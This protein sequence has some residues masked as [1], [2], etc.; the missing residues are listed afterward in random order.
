M[1]PEIGRAT[2]GQKSGAVS[3]DD[4]VIAARPTELTELDTGVGIGTSAQI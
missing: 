2:S 1:A 4:T 3:S